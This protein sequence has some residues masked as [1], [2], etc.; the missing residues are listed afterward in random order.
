MRAAARNN[1]KPTYPRDRLGFRCVRTLCTTSKDCD[2]S[3]ACTTDA[4]SAGT[5]SN[6][7]KAGYCVIDGKCWANGT[8]NP[9]NKCE[10]CDDSKST[11]SWTPLQCTLTLAGPAIVIASWSKA[12][13]SGIQFVTKVKIRLIDFQF[14]NGGKADTVIVAEVGGSQLLKVN[15][16]SGQTAYTVTA[17]IDL[18]ASKKYRIYAKNS[19]KNVKYKHKPPLPQQNAHI[20]VVEAYQPHH[21][22]AKPDGGLSYRWFGFRYLRTMPK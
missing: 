19:G 13:D 10:K 9:G 17:N 15:T 4:C 22:D 3:L 12:K 16:P 6:T 1:L 14:H 5:C 8:V 2:D 20:S 18:A 7:I 21:Q 11:I